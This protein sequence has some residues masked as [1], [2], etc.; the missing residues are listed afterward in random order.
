MPDAKRFRRYWHF[1]VLFLCAAGFVLLT[2]SPAEKMPS[3]IVP[4]VMAEF[5]GLGFGIALLPK[6]RRRQ[7]LQV[8]GLVLMFITFYAGTLFHL[9]RTQ[10]TAGVAFLNLSIVLSLFVL[11]LIFPRKFFLSFLASP[12]KILGGILLVIIFI[13][14]L[15]FV[16][17]KYQLD[18]HPYFLRIASVALMFLVGGFIHLYRLWSPRQSKNDEPRM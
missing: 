9:R 4:L 17:L 13:F 16:A 18:S 3:F 2:P 1:A 8:A 5:V 15:S 10:P 7:L 11:V 12:F 6:G 14:T